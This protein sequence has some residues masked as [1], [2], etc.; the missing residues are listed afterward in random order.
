MG[1]G[2]DPLASCKGR[3]R[4]SCWL[5]RAGGCPR[6]TPGHTT[7]SCGLQLHLVPGRLEK[8]V[9]PTKVPA[10]PSCWVQMLPWQQEGAGQVRQVLQ[11][12]KA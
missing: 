1:R 5:G 11:G 10:Q 3:A 9:A 2:L 7:P 12:Q 4:G 8:P 6:S